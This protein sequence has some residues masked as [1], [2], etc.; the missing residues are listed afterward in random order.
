M[1]SVAPTRP[2]LMPVPAV[3]STSTWRVCLAATPRA[4]QA[5]LICVSL[6]EKPPIP[7]T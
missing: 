7:A 1:I 3:L 2:S 5:V 4:N 6:P